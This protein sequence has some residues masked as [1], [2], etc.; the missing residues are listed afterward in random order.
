MLKK[1]QVVKVW[2]DPYANCMISA[3]G[4]QRVDHGKGMPEQAETSLPRHID[5]KLVPYESMPCALLYF[6]GSG[7]FNR[8]MRTKALAMGY[9]L[10][11]Y[12]PIQYT[13]YK[14]TKREKQQQN[15]KTKSYMEWAV[16]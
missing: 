5:I 2:H 8:E 11:E 9:S 15:R 14:K 3:E 16:S 7:E 6:T 1:E 4:R 13:H 12:L 10:N